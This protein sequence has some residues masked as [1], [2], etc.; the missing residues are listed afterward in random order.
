MTTPL[1]P[2][3]GASGL[4]SLVAPFDQLISPALAYSCV[5]VRLLVDIIA[6][7]GDPFTLYYQPQDLTQTDYQNDVAA[8]AAIV[9]LQATGGNWVYV[10][11]TYISQMP[12]ANNIPYRGIVLGVN[13]GALPDSLDLTYVKSQVSAA[14]QDA[15]G[16]HPGA[17]TSLAV[18]SK[19]LISPQED[20]SITA[21]REALM[22][23]KG[24]PTAQLAAARAQIATLQQQIAMLS[25][26]IQSLVDDGTIPGGDIPGTG[27]GTKILPTVTATFDP[28]LLP[29]GMELANSNMTVA[30][31][32]NEWLTART[33]YGQVSGYFYAEAT[34]DRLTGAVG[35]GLT[36]Q[37]GAPVGE[38][39]ADANSIMMFTNVAKATS[40]VYYLGA[41]VDSTGAQPPSQGITVGMAVNLTDALIWFYNPITQQW[42][43]DAPNSQNPVGNV[44]GISI[45]SI[46]RHNAQAAQVFPAASTWQVADQVTFN[47]GNSAFINAVPA[48]YLAWNTEAG[49]GS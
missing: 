13:L 7:G 2:N 4:W 39:G 9:S 3:V 22:G 30:A 49:S 11:S 6:A 47:P 28:E 40:G 46:C 36:N 43:G 38:L 12:N 34:Y 35:F 32:A 5:A 37:F 42:N 23:S 27:G 16:V 18:T 14:V 44:G 26:F 10:P 41:V 8:G 17:V 29:D 1:N 48:S 15:I 45:Q 19:T 25:Q 33:T 24:T 21:S 20:A 31:S